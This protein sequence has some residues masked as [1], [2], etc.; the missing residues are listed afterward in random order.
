MILLVDVFERSESQRVVVTCLF[1][2]KLVIH[3]IV[4][5]WIWIGLDQGAKFIARR[6]LNYSVLRLTRFVLAS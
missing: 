4:A 3:H 1:W 2:K 6:V 5:I